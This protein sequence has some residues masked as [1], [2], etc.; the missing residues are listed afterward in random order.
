MT[1]ETPPPPA[2][3]GGDPAAP[4]S[5]LLGLRAFTMARVALGR[6]GV[7]LT[8]ADHLRF[9]LDHAR[10]R[11]AVHAPLDLPALRCSLERL[12]LD[13]LA[14]ASR[15]RDRREFLLRPDLGRLLD[16]ESLALLASLPPGPKRPDLVLALSEG[17]S[18]V[19]LERQAL[20]FLER[21]LPLAR[22]RGWA[23]APLCHV[24]QGRVAV[25]DD[26]G[27]ALGAR[28]VAVLIGERPGLS[29]PDSMG[30]YLTYA[31]RRGLTDAARNC[32]SNIRPDGLPHAR[33]AMTLD[34]LLAKALALGFSG[35]DL[36]DDL[37]L[38]GPAPRNALPGAGRALPPDAPGDAT[39]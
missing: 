30:V 4:T 23:V 38:D 19:A 10:A 8:T 29:S 33:A 34:H 28:A 36:K 20:P 2:R 26:V 3:S 13:Q 37:A 1:A 35:V 39:G 25:G 15:A 11:D 24:A 22:S 16:E 14:L 5:P 6:A 21:F 9:T 12:G 17:L 18:A 31:P 32:I 27:E 7:S